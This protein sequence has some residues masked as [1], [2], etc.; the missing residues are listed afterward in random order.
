M[1]RGDGAT[2][3]FASNALAARVVVEVVD[4]R[5]FARTTHRDVDGLEKIGFVVNRTG[6]APL[7]EDPSGAVAL[8][9]RISA[10]KVLEVV[11]VSVCSVALGQLG[12]VW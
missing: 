10:S 6:D 1:V 7:A 12:S 2:W 9:T 8:A 3:A 11:N 5:G 4:D